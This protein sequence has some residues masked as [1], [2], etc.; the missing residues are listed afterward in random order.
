MNEFKVETNNYTAE[1]GRASGAVINVSINSGTN[2]LH[3]DAYKYN[4]N[5]SFNAIG[6]FTP[7]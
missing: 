3:G 6:S 4:R 1:Y 7:R 5:T 2:K